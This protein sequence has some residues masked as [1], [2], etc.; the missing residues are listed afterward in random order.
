MVDDS[1]LASSLDAYVPIVRF[2]ACF[3][4]RNCEVVLH[5]LRIPG[6]SILSIENNHVS[7]RNVGDSLHN[8]AAFFQTHV[9][10]ASS[11]VIK[12]RIVSTRNGK[13]IRSASYVI[14]DRSGA[15]IGLLCL[16]MDLGDRRRIREMLDGYLVAEPTDSMHE[17]NREE[18]EPSSEDS[19][20]DLAHLII[21]ETI[22]GYGVPASRM[23]VEEK[24][25]IVD[26]LRNAGFSFCA[27]R[28]AKSRAF[29]IL[30][31]TPSTGT[32][33]SFQTRGTERS[34]LHDDG[35]DTRVTHIIDSEFY[36][37]GWGT[38]EMREVF[39]DRRRYQRWLDIEAHWPTFRPCSASSPGGGRRDR[40][41]GPDRTARYRSDQG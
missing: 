19:I 12:P 14:R 16:N 29:S 30:P 6:S 40:T 21:R 36:R 26:R 28:S 18:H 41:E 23:T 22:S 37:D 10:P 38:R 34:I 3:L 8:L 15:A 2:L 7:G 27:E 13:T 11:D 31:R 9:V 35:E 1:F 25:S 5:D 4:G 32:S 33:T 24:L 20:E 17:G 39:S